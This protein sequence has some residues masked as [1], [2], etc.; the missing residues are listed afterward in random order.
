MTEMSG[1]S[2]DRLRV[3][4]DNL[5]R[6]VF[7]QPRLEMRFSHLGYPLAALVL[8]VTWPAANFLSYNYRL[9]RAGGESFVPIILFSLFVI[10]AVI[11]LAAKLAVMGQ[12][13]A[14]RLLVTAAILY[15]LLFLFQPFAQLFGTILSVPHV[16]AVLSWPG[17][18]RDG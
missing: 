16:G 15:P 17:S 6:L 11:V 3:N 10:A 8:A 2:P 4:F 5:R 13:R 18:P 1:L 9:V 7:T 14:D 12:S